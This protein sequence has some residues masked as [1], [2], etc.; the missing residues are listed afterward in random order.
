[1]NRLDIADHLGLTIE[2]VSRTLSRLDREGCILNRAGGCAPRRP[3]QTRSAVGALTLGIAPS[4]LPQ[5]GD[6]RSRRGSK[7]RSVHDAR[8]KRA[9]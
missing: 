5:G 4:G 7:P 6:E 8:D 2:T 9:S 3:R 1:M